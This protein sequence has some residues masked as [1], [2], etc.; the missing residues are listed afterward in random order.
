MS[1]FVEKWWKRQNLTFGDLWWPDRRP[2]LKSARSGFVMIFDALS[3]DSCRVSLHGPGAELQGVFTLPPAR[4]VRRRAAAR[5]QHRLDNFHTHD[6]LDREGGGSNLSL[7][8]CY[9]IDPIEVYMEPCW[10]RDTTKPTTRY[11]AV[12]YDIPTYRGEARF[13]K[14]HLKTFPKCS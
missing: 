4:R 12:R 14:H 8:T 9:L 2:D 7:S 11:T 3:N 5:R 6:R 1:R 13:S 10:A